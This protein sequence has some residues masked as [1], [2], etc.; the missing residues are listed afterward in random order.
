MVKIG[1]RKIVGGEECVWMPD[2]WSWLVAFPCWCSI[3]N[4]RKDGIRIPA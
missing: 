2:P 4:L 3:K 1:D